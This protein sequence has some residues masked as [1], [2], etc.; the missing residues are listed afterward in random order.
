MVN[1]FVKNPTSWTTYIGECWPGESAYIDFLNENAQDYWGNWLSFDK[2][3]GSTKRYHLWNDMNEPTVY[4][5]DTTVMPPDKMHCRANSKCFEHRDLHNAYGGLQQKA[6][7]KGLLKRDNNELRPFTLTRSWFM[8]SQRFGAYWTG[9]NTA[10]MEELSGAIIMIMQNGISGH[11]FGG[12]DIPGFVGDADDDLFIMFYQLG[13]YL[14]FMRAHSDIH[15]PFREPWFQT[16]RVQTA[17]R[18]SINRRYD[19]IKYIYTMFEEATRMGTPL[20]RPMWYEIP[21]ESTA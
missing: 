7:Y 12:A 3:K 11:P 16:D 17:I 9:D 5:S 1:I 4:D 13:T 19:L 2:F 8:G 18:A 14:P 15:N 6:S 20:M 21:M 10:T